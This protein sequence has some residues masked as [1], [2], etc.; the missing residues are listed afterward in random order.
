DQRVFI[1]LDQNSIGRTTSVEA[2]KV[3]LSVATV[4]AEIALINQGAS[5]WVWYDRDDDG[6][7]DLV[8]RS[9][10]VASGVAHQAYVL[11]ANGVPIAAPEHVGRRLLRPALLAKPELAQRLAS[12]E[13]SAW[14]ASPSDDALASFPALAR[15]DAATI[16]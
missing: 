16:V 12:N 6:S 15:S 11:S 14:T 2:L 9:H 5:E 10:D 4:D 1:D 13:I 7:F 3:L 8:L